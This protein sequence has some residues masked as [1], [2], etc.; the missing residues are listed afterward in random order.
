MH[1]DAF[2]QEMHTHPSASISRPLYECIFPPCP[3][4][5]NEDRIAMGNK[6]TLQ[7]IHC[8]RPTQNT[9]ARRNNSVCWLQ[10]RHRR[11]GLALSAD[12]IIIAQHLCWTT[13]LFLGVCESLTTRGAEV[14]ILNASYGKYKKDEPCNIFWCDRFAPNQLILINAWLN[15]II[16]SAN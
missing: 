10:N 6:G 13:N 4:I 5:R 12:K 7:A 1:D 11:W 14:S 2:V 3:P 16:T 9:T 15:K 8:L